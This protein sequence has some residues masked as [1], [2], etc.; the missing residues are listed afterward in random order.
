MFSSIVKDIQFLI[1]FF[2]DGVAWSFDLSSK[3]FF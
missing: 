3:I 1:T 2:L